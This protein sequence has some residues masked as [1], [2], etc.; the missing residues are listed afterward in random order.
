MAYYDMQTAKAQLAFRRFVIL[1]FVLSI[2]LGVLGRPVMTDARAIE[3]DVP[4][5]AKDAPG[6]LNDGE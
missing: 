5:A 2:G 6:A 3:G 1:C 4:I